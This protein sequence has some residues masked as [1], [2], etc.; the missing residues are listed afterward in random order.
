M[1]LPPKLDKELA[2]LKESFRIEIHT[3]A[4]FVSLIFPEFPVGEGF[5]RTNSDLMVRV[6]LSY[7]DAGPDMFY[8][9]PAL[10]LARGTVPQSAEAIETH[11]G[12]QWRRFSWHHGPWNRISDNLTGYLE[13]VRDRLRRKA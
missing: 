10:L 9:D 6:P 11:A 4:S 1:A 7:P 5:N 12:R 3:D 13:F 2:Q 8:T